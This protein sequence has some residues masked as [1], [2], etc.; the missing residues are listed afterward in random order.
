MKNLEKIKIQQREP[1]I[2]DR[3]SYRH[4]EGYNGETASVI[5][6]DLR[7]IL[8]V[9]PVGISYNFNEVS[10]DYKQPHEPLRFCEAIHLAMQ[11]S[12]DI[13]LKKEDISCPAA[14]AVLGFES[15]NEILLECAE[16][17]VEA[18]RFRDVGSAYQVLS[19]VP[20]IRWPP[21]SVFLSSSAASPDVYVCYLRP[22]DMMKVIQAHEREFL[23]PLRLDIT[24]ITPICGGCADR[25]YTSNVICASFGCEDL[26]EYGGISDNELALGVPFKKATQLLGSLLEMYG[27]EEGHPHF[28]V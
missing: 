22:V 17:L 10:D 11:T 27:D 16:K 15:N 6:N 13:L 20:K 8:D 2:L 28:A 12:R 9:S 1:I 4:K 19:E 24:G 7:K 18:G 5:I 26:R 23:E 21:S 14:R 25:P 3:K